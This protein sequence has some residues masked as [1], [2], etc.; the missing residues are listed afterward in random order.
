MGAKSSLA[1]FN[2][3]KAEDWNVARSQMQRMPVEESKVN[4]R[5]NAAGGQFSA[6]RRRSLNGRKSVKLDCDTFAAAGV[7]GV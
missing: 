5:C 3:N 2:N 7:A 4:A 1:D 6:L